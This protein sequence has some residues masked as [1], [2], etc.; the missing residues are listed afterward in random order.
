M[1]G[2]HNMV[3]AMAQEA[4]GAHLIL[5]SSVA[6]YGDSSG[7]SPP[8]RVTH[9]QQALD[10]Y[11]ESKIRAEEVM[12]TSR[13]TYTIL[14][15]SGVAVPAFLAPPQVWPFMREQRMEFV[16]RSD[17]VRALLA[18]VEISEARGRVFN[19]AG[20]ESWRML[21]CQYVERFNEVMGLPPEE[22][23][24]LATPGWYDWYDT[25]AGQAILDYQKTSF[26]RFLE[27]FRRAI[28]KTL[29]I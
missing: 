18:S 29:A 25:S 17:V 8:V 26:P 21:G 10:F 4:P 3:E 23:P 24:Y 11:A 9:P 14:R 27:L 5:S 19:I 6:I 12:S 15:I 28:E 1:E 16:A 7:E 22:G 20:G 13:L 2:T